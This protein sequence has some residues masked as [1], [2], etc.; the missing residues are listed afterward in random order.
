[1]EFLN[2]WWILS[3]RA[4]ACV[5]CAGIGWCRTELSS[6]QD[7]TRPTAHLALSCYQPLPRLVD[8]LRVYISVA[9]YHHSLTPPPTTI[10][11]HHQLSP[12]FHPVSRFSLFLPFPF[13]GSGS[14]RSIAMPATPML[15]GSLRVDNETALLKPRGK[16]FKIQSLI[17]LYTTR[18]ARPMCHYLFFIIFLRSRVKQNLMGDVFY[19][20]FSSRQMS[21]TTT[22]LYE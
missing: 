2:G 21:F 15:W 4:C 20:I 8:E 16:L 7:H 12:L 10:I 19:F 1:M 11:H 6:S 9:D 13:R 14:K 17:Q 22:L 3:D 18:F 5:C